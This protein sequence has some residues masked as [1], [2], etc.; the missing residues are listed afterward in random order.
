M[1][2]EKQIQDCKKKNLGQNNDKSSEQQ[3]IDVDDSTEMV[4]IFNLLVFL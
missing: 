3:E 2:I 4:C 1:T